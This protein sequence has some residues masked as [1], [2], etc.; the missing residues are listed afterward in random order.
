MA[1]KDSIL[2]SRTLYQMGMVVLI[3]SIAWVGIGIYS[4]LNKQAT[5]TVDQSTLEPIDTSLDMAVVE[6]M[7]K[8]LK[9]EGEILTAPVPEIV[10]I[11]VVTSETV[12]SG[13]ESASIETVPTEQDELVE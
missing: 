11:D 4:S 3:V 7:A 5:I 6:E 12:E 13:S 2:V 1:S 9:I 10:E 8:R